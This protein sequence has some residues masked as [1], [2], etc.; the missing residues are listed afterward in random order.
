MDSKEYHL[1]WKDG[2]QC[3]I[4][5]ASF[6][7]FD[8]SSVI[9]SVDEYIEEVWLC[10]MALSIFFFSFFFL[11]SLSPIFAFAFAFCIFAFCFFVFFFFFR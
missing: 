9:E 8:P 6:E 2:K 11:N 3:W 10:V 4:L 7:S 1:E 5:W